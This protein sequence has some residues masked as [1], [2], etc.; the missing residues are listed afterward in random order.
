MSFRAKLQHI[1][2]EL[3]GESSI[4]KVRR[5]TQ[6][7]EMGAETGD[8]LHC[9]GP[10]ITPEEDA[11]AGEAPRP[12]CISTPSMQFCSSVTQLQLA[13]GRVRCLVGLTHH[14]LP[15]PLGQM[16]QA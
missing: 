6:L 16:S 7:V 11:I 5:G 15:H 8:N 3:E 13:A 10:G 9:P 4:I 1:A 14:S 12:C 2:L